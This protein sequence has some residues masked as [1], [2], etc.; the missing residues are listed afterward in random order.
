MADGSLTVV[1][2][3]DAVRPQSA[4]PI[5]DENSDDVISIFSNQ[6]DDINV[7][8]YNGFWE[9]STT[10]SET[11]QVNGDD[12]LRYTMMNFVGIQFT[13]PTIDIS[14]MTHIHLDIWTPISTA[15]PNTFKVLLV[16]LGAD[17]TFEGGDNTSHELTFTSPTLQTESWV[18]LDIPISEFTGLTTKR[19]LAQIVL[20]GELPTVFVDNIYFYKGSGTGGPSSPEM[21]APNPTQNGAN[22]ISIFSDS[23]NSVDANLNPNWGQSNVVT[24]EVINGN[25]TLKYAGLDYQGIELASSQNVTEMEFLHIDYWTSNSSLLNVFLISPGPEETAYSM[26]VP[27]VGW[28][29]VDIPLSEFAGVDLADVFQFKFDGNGTIFLDNIFF[30]KGGSSGGDE[31][32]PAAPAPALSS[33]D[34]ISLFSDSYNDVVVDTWRTDWSSA[35]FEDVMVVGQAVKKYSNLDFVGIETV[36]S[37]IDATEMTH[38]HID[39]WSKDF[40]GFGIKLVD[41]GAD[42]AFGGGDDVEHQVDYVSPTQEG[43]ISYDI[44]LSDFTGLTTR[45]N[46]SQYILVGLPTSGTTVFIDNMYFHK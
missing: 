7:D 9:F 11:V 31:P 8:F 21:A 24:T 1:S 12:I 28:G 6:Y 32:T 16:D 41:F 34:V 4:A 39:V 19:N 23:Y 43:W 5:P 13:S 29:S 30:Y 18:S 3:G 33:D 37:Q 10:Q 27:T 14:E 46:L 44:P 20:S 17:G 26:P 35:D 25:N 38:F 40:T 42:G 36:A 15:S 22:V 2:T 45:E